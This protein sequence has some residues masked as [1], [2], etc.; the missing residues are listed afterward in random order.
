V[1]LKLS[2]LNLKIVEG[3]MSLLHLR[4]LGFAQLFIDIKTLVMLKQSLLEHNINYL[5]RLEVRVIL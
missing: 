1:F 3:K 2:C 5:I 4:E